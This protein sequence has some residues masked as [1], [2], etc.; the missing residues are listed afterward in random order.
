MRLAFGLWALILDLLPKVEGGARESVAS[1]GIADCGD[2]DR[3]KIDSEGL[4][5]EF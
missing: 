5:R 1:A 4:Y 3:T 2:D